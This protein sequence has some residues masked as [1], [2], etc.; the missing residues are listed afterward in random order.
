[1]SILRTI[2]QFRDQVTVNVSSDFASFA[3]DVKLV[4]AERLKPLMGP[5]LYNELSAL[6]DAA[7]AALTGPLGALRDELLCA[8]ANLAMVEYLP[9]QQV[10][11]SDVGVHIVTTGDK[12]TAFQWQI[13]QLLAGFRR[14]G[15]NALERALTLLDEH[16]D[17]PAFAAWATSAAGTASHKYFLNTATQF[18]EHYGINNS[19]LTYLALLPTLRKMERFALEPALG[20]AYYLELKEQVMDRDVS[21]DNLLVLEQ[22]LRPALAHLVVAKAVPELGLG[23]NGDAIELNVYRP[24]DANAKEADASI[25]ALLTLKVQQAEADGLVYLARLR[26][27]LNSA[28]SPT[29]YAAYYTS[30]AYQAPGGPRPTVRTEVAG[31]IYSL[32]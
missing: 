27:Y 22:Y 20:S 28:A 18:S 19:R 1:M 12:K 7:L 9:L 10:Q 14:K 21:A 32:F 6:P 3:P 31:R 24:D 23:L 13:N 25:D 2:E 16:V 15:F 4:E 11:I 26:S 29:R 17:L 30:A 8:A 5:A